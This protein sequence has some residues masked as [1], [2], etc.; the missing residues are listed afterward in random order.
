MQFDVPANWNRLVYSTA[1]Q[2]SLDCFE[3]NLISISHFRCYKL[4]HQ[5]GRITYQQSAL[6]F[7]SNLDNLLSLT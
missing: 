7:Q 1:Y 6:I 3:I 4:S 2:L 5:F